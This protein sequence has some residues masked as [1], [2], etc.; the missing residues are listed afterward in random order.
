MASLGST[1]INVEHLSQHAPLEAQLEAVA[2]LSR[3]LDLMA[4]GM[5]SPDESELDGDPEILQSL[6]WPLRTIASVA[7]DNYRKDSGKEVA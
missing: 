5:C 1:L 4:A 6:T 2:D 7:L 3:I